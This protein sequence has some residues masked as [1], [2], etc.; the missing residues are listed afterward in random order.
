MRVKNSIKNTITN[1]IC[2]ISIILIGLISQAIFIKIMDAEYLGINGLF[3][4]ILSFLGIVELGIGNAIVY[5]LY[6]PIANNEYDTIKSLICFY[7]KA[8]NII[9]FI[10][11]ILG[12]LIVPFLPFFIG[13]TNLDLNFNIVYILFLLNMISTYILSFR[14]SIFLASQQNYKVKINNLFYRLTVNLLQLIF[15]YFTKNY[16]LYL[17]IAII[18]QLFFNYLINNKALKEF[19]YLREKKV[20][21]LSKEIE[22]DIFKKIKALFFHKIGGFIVNG[23]DNIIIS[24][25]FN[26][27]TVGLYSNYFLI[28]NSLTTL[29][30]Q[31]IT[32][33]TASVGN[34]LVTETKEKSFDIFKKIRFLNYWIAVFSSICTLCIIQSFISVWIGEQYLLDYSVVIILVINY[35]QKIMRNTY[36]SFKDAAGIWEEDKLIPIVESI[37]NIIFSILCLKIF[38]LSGVFMGTV[39]SGLALWCYSY[40][41]FVYKKLFNR[42]YLDYAKETLGYIFLFV[43]LA[44]GTY[45]IST[46]IRFSNVWYQLI[47]NSFLSMIIPNIFLILIFRKNDNFQYFM[48][49]IKKI[50]KKK[51]SNL[52]R[53]FVK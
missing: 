4:N 32:G 39:I 44:S 22:T 19:P 26:V 10:I 43:I 20:E 2:N 8:Y 6:K 5:N 40:P 29:F 38:G 52:Q 30:N 3:T 18:T 24:K 28:I 31:I 9:A 53:F 36:N 1:V 13:Q 21:K 46:I 33:T 37:L 48:S 16:Y 17:I 25:F 50:F 47:S 34:M 11:F 51:E 23:T 45:Y 12:I 14:T 49:L 35:Y 42:S 27:L 7:K 41:K 15:L